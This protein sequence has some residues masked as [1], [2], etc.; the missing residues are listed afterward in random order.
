MAESPDPVTRWLPRPRAVRPADLWPVL[1]QTAAGTLAWII[2][3]YVVNHHDPFFAPI[4]AV[5]ALNTPLGDRGLNAL[6][7]LLGVLT[8]IV[9][10]EIALYLLGS[11]YVA[12]ALSLFAALAT[13]RAFDAPR[14]VLAQAASA[15]ILTVVT[16]TG[17]RG[18]Q[19]LIDALIGA[20]VALVFSQLLFPPRPIA[21]LHAAERAALSGI[22][23]GLIMSARAMRAG[24]EALAERAV[25]ELR[26][27]RDRLGE[28]AR[29]R[30]ASRRVAAHS[31]RWRGQLPRVVRQSENAGSLD[32]LA[33]SALMLA[34]AAMPKGGK[35]DVLAGN[36]DELARVVRA[37]AAA[38]G[39]RAARQRAAEQVLAVLELIDDPRV[40]WPLDLPRDLPHG[41]L[42]MVAVD[43]LAFT[44]LEPEW[45]AGKAAP[46]T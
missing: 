35:H 29:T 39:D 36:V 8:G 38:P 11:G 45:R 46:G 28:L 9:F 30:S 7:L 6:R 26:D 27:L 10:G 19:R 34:R 2:A 20:G 13:A 42:M 14:I 4:A 17:E 12:L 31:L 24:D 32:L 16:G 1:Q 5:V 22:A 3:G 40:Q 25:S 41:L 37:L 44:G 43:I 18:P 15:A 21:L 23:D 33:G